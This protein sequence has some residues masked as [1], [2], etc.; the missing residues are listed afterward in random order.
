MKVDNHRSKLWFQYLSSPVSMSMIGL[1]DHQHLAQAIY[2]YMQD[3]QDH[4]SHSLLL[5]I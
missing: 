4:Q 5:Q 2:M 3:H 1:Y